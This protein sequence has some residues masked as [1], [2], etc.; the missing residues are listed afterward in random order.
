MQFNS[1]EF[2]FYFL[3]LFLAV[4]YL[5]PDR[6]RNGVLFLSSLLFYWMACGNRLWCLGL[7]VGLTLFTYVIGLL[8]RRTRGKWLLALVLAALAAVLLFFKC[9]DGGKLLPAGLSFYLFQM[10]AYLIDVSRRRTPAERNLLAY[11]AQTAMF[12]KLLSG[13]L[14]EPKKL[15][16]QSKNPCFCGQTFHLGLQE[17]I[18]GLAL[19]VLL[20]DRLG[21]LWSQAGVIGY[22]NISTPFAWMA[23]AAYAMRLYFDFYGYSLMAVGLGHMLGYH[24]PMN[25]LEPYSAKSVSEFYRRWHA[26]LGAWFRNYIY[27]PLGGSRKGMGR[28]ILNLCVVWALTGFWHGV[29]GNYLLWAGLLCLLIINEKLW[30]R[31]L[32]NRSK[33]LCH[34]YTVF[35]ILIS[36]VPFAIGDWGSMTVFLGR[37]FGAA[38]GVPNARD[39][40]IWG[41]DFAPL[42]AAGIVFATPLPKFLW[43]KVRK[44][45]VVDVILFALFWVVVFFIATS[46]QDPFLYFQY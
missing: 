37:L 38:A 7:L 41:K 12:P 35:V 46:A 22:A 24:L 44:Y 40:L 31:K 20:A 43:K 8:L 36:W 16:L 23:L 10:I 19:K 6:W 18:L 14:M 11:G 30:I 1:I 39:Y 45:A 2:I 34:L 27:F 42:L 13:P 26:T 28:T 29:G 33:V 9:Y 3:P 4:Y 21:G 15:Y 25:F 17:L 32:L 5:A